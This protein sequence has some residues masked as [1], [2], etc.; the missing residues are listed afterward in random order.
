[1]RGINRQLVAFGEG[2]RDEE[3]KAECGMRNIEC[4][5]QNI[6]YRMRN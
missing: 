6:E 4:G 5:I 1:M 2:T 3:S